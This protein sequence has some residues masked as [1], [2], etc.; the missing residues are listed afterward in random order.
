MS[1]ITFNG[2]PFDGEVL[3]MGWAG[4]ADEMRSFGCVRHS[5]CPSAGPARFVV[6]LPDGRGGVIFHAYTDSI[7]A[8]LAMLDKERKS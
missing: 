4:H 2:G 1:T 8:G 3:D 5:E 6:Y 7:N